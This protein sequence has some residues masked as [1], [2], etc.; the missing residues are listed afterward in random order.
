MQNVDFNEI[1]PTLG[2]DVVIHE[3][4]TEEY[5]VHQTKLNH[6]VRINAFA[7]QL[8]TLLDGKK[9]ITT[10]RDEM[11]KS[12]DADVA[13]GDVYQLLYGKL[14][15]YGMIDDNPA[16]TERSSS[17]YLALRFTLLRR[18]WVNMLSKVFYFLFPAT[19]VFNVLFITLLLFVAGN[20]VHFFSRIA[21]AKE[22]YYLNG[23]FVL[24][25]FLFSFVICLFHEV[26]H[27][28]ALRSYKKNA[29]QIGVGFFLF[30]PVFFCDVSEAWFLKK[31]QRVVVNLGG[32]YFELLVATA[33]IAAMYATENII[34]IF[35]ASIILLRAAMNLNPF[36]RRD[37]Y[38]ILSDLTNRPNLQRN[39][40]AHFFSQI[41]RLFGKGQP[42]KPLDLFLF[43]YGI[44]S[45]FFV[46]FFLLLM[47]FFNTHSI[48]YFPVR[49]PALVM[50]LAAKGL[51]VKSIPYFLQ[52]LGL[53]LL[54]YYLLVKLLISNIRRRVTKK[55]AATINA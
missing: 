20:V 14:F 7:Y 53:P 34:F 17:N 12:I 36:L 52:H 42:D 54:F 33:F 25:L 3:V 23:S 47:V 38:W 10:L 40:F 15:G 9:S 5:V 21:N 11:A 41:G 39:S 26:G 49:L 29:G 28:S 46:V 48:L 43:I 35:L 32:I 1:K 37:G 18:S 8:L 31:K 51:D 55:P 13:A 4:T 22:S 27:A 2:R 45:L 19:V 6:Q 30:Y 44:L 50:E 24:L 16:A